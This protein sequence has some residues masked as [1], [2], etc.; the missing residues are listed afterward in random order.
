MRGF[1]QQ[2]WATTGRLLSASA[3]ASR[4]RLLRLPAAE[5]KHSEMFSKPGRRLSAFPAGCRPLGSPSCS[6]CSGLA[7]NDAQR[8]RRPQLHSRA[9]RCTLSWHRCLQHLSRRD[10]HGLASASAMSDVSCLGDRRLR[11]PPDRHW[12]NCNCRSSQSWHT[13]VCFTFGSVPPHASAPL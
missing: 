1:F 12:N 8:Q 6:S 9:P 13:D 5:A 2:A 11:I 10:G 3:P 7:E 4:C